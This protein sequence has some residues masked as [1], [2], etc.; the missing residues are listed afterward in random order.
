VIE[1]LRE[2]AEITTR[3]G[4]TTDFKLNEIVLAAPDI[5]RKVFEQFAARFVS[6]AKGG[7]TLYASKNDFAMTAS[8]RVASG[9][10]RAGDVP[11]E[12]IVIVPG[13]ESIDISEASTG[14]F[15][16]NHSTF[17]D[18]GHLVAD[19]QLLFERSSDK[20]PPHV[21]FRVYRQEGTQQKLWW[22]YLKN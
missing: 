20:H 18:R 15:S 22:R 14:F 12:G 19:M 9:L 6:L 4:R 13:V 1:V 21:R 17:A 16:S 11:R 2:Q 10:V 7:V 8:K 5:S 3:Q